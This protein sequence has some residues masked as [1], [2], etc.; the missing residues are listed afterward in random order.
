MQ[1]TGSSSNSSSIKQAA[2]H[3]A[4]VSPTPGY[5]RTSSLVLELSSMAERS[6][7]CGALEDNAI[8]AAAAAAVAVA[9][10]TVAYAPVK[11]L[12]TRLLPK[13][14]FKETAT[15]TA[16]ATPT[17]TANTNNNQDS[18][19]PFLPALSDELMEH[20]LVTRLVYISSIPVMNNNNSTSSS[21]SSSSSSCNGNS[22][23]NN[24]SNSSSSSGGGYS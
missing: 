16:T 8:A 22:N 3:G 21:S 18:P 23:N 19:I 20:H 14:I 4:T 13:Q 1:A 2:I 12:Y 11:F 5:S 7:H 15:V 9:A 6:Q 24:S 10:F 17:A